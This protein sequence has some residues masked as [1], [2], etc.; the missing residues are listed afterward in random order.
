MFAAFRN[1]MRLYTSAFDRNAPVPAHLG[2]DTDFTGEILEGRTGRTPNGAGPSGFAGGGTTFEGA[3]DGR[4]GVAGIGRDPPGGPP[5]VFMEQPATRPTNMPITGQQLRAEE[6]RVLAMRNI[7]NGGSV[8][9]YDLQSAEGGSDDTQVDY[10][11]IHAGTKEVTVTREGLL[12]FRTGEDAP[13][14]AFTLS[15]AFDKEVERRAAANNPHI[16]MWV[17]YFNH[18]RE[19]LLMRVHYKTVINLDRE[20]RRR[21]GASGVMSY[22][23]DMVDMVLCFALMREPYAQHRDGDPTSTMS[24]DGNNGGRGGD[25]GGGRGGRGGRGGCQGRGGREG[26]GGR[27]G[28]GHGDQGVCN[29]HIQLLEGVCPHPVSLKTRL[30]PLRQQQTRNDRLRKEKVVV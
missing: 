9:G 22:S 26:H 8:A 18:L 23:H 14:N 27:E 5:G 7:Q 19:I 25:G 11:N 1:L 24:F 29:H 10:D 12:M 28:R 21:W 6:Q 15:A 20:V 13:I 4:G 17:I 16:S 2:D 30:L 3:A